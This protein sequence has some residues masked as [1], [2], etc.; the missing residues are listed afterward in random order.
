[1]KGW[2]RVAQN[3]NSERTDDMYKIPLKTGKKKKLST[4]S[5]NPEDGGSVFH[6]HFGIDLKP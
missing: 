4:K 2:H 6:G 1:M 3:H 5:H